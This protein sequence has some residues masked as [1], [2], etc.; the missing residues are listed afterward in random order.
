MK[1][2]ASEKIY[3]AANTCLLSLISLITLFPLYY[4]FVVSFTEPSEFIRGG[5]ILFPRTW[6]TISYEYLLSTR[7][8]IRSILN[9]GFLATVGTLSSLIVT[10]GLAYMLSRKRLV[11]RRVIT[12]LILLTILFSPGMIPNYLVVRELGLIN[13]IW[14][15]IIP[16][17]SSGWYVL[18]MKGFFDSIPE[19][20]EEAATIDGCNDVGIWLRIILPLSL[21]AMAAF[22]LFFAVGYWNTYFSAVLYI[23]NPAK[24]PLQILLQNLLVDPYMAGGSEGAYVG[25]EQLNLPPEGL[26]MAAIVM[27]TIPILLVYP[28]L[29]KHFA[30]GAM[31]GSVKE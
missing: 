26:K 19:S 29:Q 7:T 16:A 23:N 14:A 11:G 3:Y 8:F 2:R 20:L 27:T 5:V 15:L 31:V 21:P 18:L 22:G 13:Q 28:F 30:K 9:S 12:L 4:V 17:L 1:R 6:T 24:W 25:S 10:S